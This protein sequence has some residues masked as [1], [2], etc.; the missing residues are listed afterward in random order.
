M[1][2]SSSLPAPNPAAKTALL[3]G[4]RRKEVPNRDSCSVLRGPPPC[5]PHFPLAGTVSARFRFA[6]P[7]RYECA[8]TVQHRLAH[9][10]S[11]LHPR[12][13]GRLRFRLVK[14]SRT[15]RIEPHTLSR[16]I[17]RKNIR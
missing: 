2:E 5:E 15:H 6:A 3:G 7:A 4:G 9:Q 1:S 10:C 13:T 12:E 8:Q 11:F 14:A 16:Q 17:T